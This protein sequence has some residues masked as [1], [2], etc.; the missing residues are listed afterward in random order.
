MDLNKWAGRIRKYTAQ[1]KSHPFIFDSTG[2]F[3]NEV[4]QKYFVDTE[5]SVVS[6]P[7]NY[8]RLGISAIAKADDGM[9]L[10]LYLSYFG[11]KESP[12][13]HLRPLF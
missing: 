1:F 13:F 8:M 3:Q 9:E 2:T 5:G 4:R 12:I 10:P 6:A 11:F 7:V